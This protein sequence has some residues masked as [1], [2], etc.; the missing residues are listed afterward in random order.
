MGPAW[1]VSSD[2]YARPLKSLIPAVKTGSIRPTPVSTS[3]IRSKPASKLRRTVAAIRVLKMNNNH[4]RT[5][6]DTEQ[7]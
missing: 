7:P 5:Q 6:T 3:G 2:V 1:I 4:P